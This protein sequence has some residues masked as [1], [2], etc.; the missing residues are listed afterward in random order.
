MKLLTAEEMREVDRQA[1]KTYGIPSIILMENAGLRMVEC[2]RKKYNELHA[3]NVLILAGRGNNGGDG[4][5]VARHLLNAGA[6]V[7]IFLLG[8]CGQLTADAL[9]NYEIL[10]KMGKTINPLVQEQDLDKFML[11]LLSADLIIDAIYG[12]GFRG[13]LGEF[14]S[15]IV[16]WVNASRARVIAA[17]IPSGVEADTGNVH[18]EAVHADETVT[19]ALPKLGL[20]LE[21]GNKYAGELTIADISI[22]QALLNDARWKTNLI[23]TKLIRKHFAVRPAESHKGSFGHALMIG[24]SAGMSGAII[25]SSYAALRTGAGLVTAAVPESLL[26]LVDGAI[27]EVMGR[28]LDETK[29]AAISAEA[30]PA[31]ENLLGTSSVCAIGPGMS[32]YPEANAILR[33]VLENAG[34]PVI[35]DAD[36]INALKGDAGILKKRQIPVVITPHPGEMAR[37]TGLSVEEIQQNR[38]KIARD[39]A[40]EWGITIVLKGNKTVVASPSGSLYINPS[41]NPGMATAGSGDVLTGIITGLIAQG[42]KPEDAA[43]AG[44][45][46]HG[47]AGD[48]ASLHTGQRGLVAGDIIQALPDTL[49]WLEKIEK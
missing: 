12:I 38:M 26:N 22:P 6:R 49:S 3:L 23:D 48:R 46:L 32:G 36:G 4:L 19:F 39:F 28:P 44:V 47:L 29:D 13:K 34:I 40:V 42:L 27:L 30:L 43:V 31:I 7:E 37:L 18:G 15:R 24:G 8:E 2:I 25:M 41:G 1:S 20:V 35:I 14:E 45:Y 17:D 5:V 10:Q 33:F 21:P 11:S 16:K 9:L